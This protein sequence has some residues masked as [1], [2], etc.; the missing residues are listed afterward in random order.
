MF[1]NEKKDVFCLKF[2]WILFL[3]ISLLD[4]MSILVQLMV[5]HQT[6][7]K[8]IP[9][10]MLIKVPGAAHMTPL[11]PNGLIYFERLRFKITLD[12]RHNGH[13][14]VSNHLPHHCLFNRLF[15]RRWKKPSK[16]RLT[17]LCVGNLPV[18][19]EFPAQ[20]VSNAEK[21][22]FD[23]VIMIYLLYIRDWLSLCWWWPG[24][25]VRYHL[26]SGWRYL[27]CIHGKKY[28]PCH[29][30]RLFT[31]IRVCIS[32]KMNMILTHSKKIL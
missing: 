25:N 11:G 1:L 20:M 5:W 12:W 4:T 19:C 17:G 31:Y 15:R 27:I 9:K 18:T 24:D 23:D 8:P 32:W 29:R 2:P 28:M 26:H 21:F 16:L 6:G 7:D 10:P 3:C 30:M 13:H 14:G 22:P